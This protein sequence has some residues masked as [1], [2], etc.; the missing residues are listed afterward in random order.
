MQ[1][2]LCLSGGG[3]RASIY[4][5]GVLTFLNELKLNDGSVMLDHIHSLSCISGG[6][7]TGMKYV[8]SIAYGENRKTTFQKLYKD[9]VKNNLGDHLLRRFDKDSKEGKALI[10]S[11]ANIYDEIFFH[12]DKFEKILNVM[13]W[14]GVHH[15]YVDA[16][17]FD[18]GLPFRFQSTVMLTSPKRKEPYG[19]IGNWRHSIDREDAKELRLA[20]IMASTSCFP[21]VFEPI[22]YPTEF[23]LGEKIV[24]KEKDLLNY[25]LMDGGLIDNQGVEPA[26]HVASHLS[27]EGK[28]LDLAIISDAGITS[29]Q[30]ADKSWK[31]WNISPK[32]L[33][34]N[35]LIVGLISSIVAIAAWKT[36]LLFVSG[37][38]TTLFLLSL[39]VAFILKNLDSRIREMIK[40]STKLEVKKS[41]V[42]TKSFRSIGT[43]IKSRV[44]SAYRMT[45]V[46]MS[47]NQKR[48]WFR[49]LHNDPIW[50]SRILMNSMTVFSSQKTWK[51]TFRKQPTL[52]KKLR[53]TTSM[54][55]LSNLA[56][57]MKTTLWFDDEDIKKGVPQAILACGRYTT[58]WNL[59]VHIDKLK[60]I[61]SAE[62]LPFQKTLIAEEDNI[63]K[64]WMKFVSNPKYNVNIYA[65]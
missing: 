33:H 53:P 36:E 49:A 27:D 21:L 62:L 47:G 42:W 65:L 48:L 18:V 64:F 6:A 3:Y 23:E 41:V 50:K 10:Q 37:C 7:L 12:G 26:Y 52:D 63:M 24:N 20:D 4:H 15:F 38:M 55:T 2:T 54:L 61:P 51:E 57:S 32:V 59:L 11:L 8:L 22:L 1:L 14:S 43:F 9:I 19:L 25:P 5:L 45:D 60:Q 16:T 35:I 28:E 30:S 39:V 13:D 44:M 34:R 29:S 58:C 17:D 40:N 46:I 56:S 31:L